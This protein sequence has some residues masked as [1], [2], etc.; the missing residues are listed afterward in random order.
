MA[1]D[2]GAELLRVCD[3]RCATDAER[4]S[5]LG[6]ALAMLHERMGISAAK[7]EGGTT[8]ERWAAEYFGLEWER[9]RKT[10]PDAHDGAGRPCEIKAALHPA[11][12]NV[13]KAKVGAHYRTP[14]RRVGEADAAFAARAEEHIRKDAGGHFWVTWMRR[15][16]RDGEH[17]VLAWWIPSAALAPLVGAKMRASKS[18][19]NARG[20]VAVSFGGVVCRTCGGVHVLDAIARALGGWC[21]RTDDRAALARLS[22]VDAVHALPDAAAL[23][24]LT[25]KHASQCPAPG[26]DK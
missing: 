15:A 11:R 26:A 16:N 6:D 25:A 4:M 20:S 22:A 8:G 14:A 2:V 21:S 17:V 9:V 12:A 7:A 24:A 1:A 23:T 18:M 3:A 19:T 5:A 10:G 13:G